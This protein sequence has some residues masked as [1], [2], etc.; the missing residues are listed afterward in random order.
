MR[1]VH[2]IL[3]S[4][5][6]RERPAWNNRAS[7]RFA[8]LVGVI[9]VGVALLAVVTTQLPYRSPVMKERID[10]R[11][12]KGIE[13]F[14]H[15]FE[16][17]GRWEEAAEFYRLAHEA[18]PYRAAVLQKLVHSYREMGDE[19]RYRQYYRKALDATLDSLAD[20]PDTPCR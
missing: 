3:P 10:R 7:R 14:A 9:F 1:N 16:N 11:V 12:L 8:G 4:P 6:S 20:Y 15:R 2:D 17:R 13:K 18:E 5:V 19:S